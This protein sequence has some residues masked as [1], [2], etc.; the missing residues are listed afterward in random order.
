MLQQKSLFL[1][2]HFS[3]RNYIHYYSNP[4]NSPISFEFYNTSLPKN[5][6]PLVIYKVDFSIDFDRIEKYTKTCLFCL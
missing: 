3:I 5:Y 2:V 4:S 6:F 1:E